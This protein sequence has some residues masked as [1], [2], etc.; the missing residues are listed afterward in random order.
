MPC[1]PW[2]V[3]RRAPLPVGFPRQEYW[4]GLPFP[5]P[6]DLPDPGLEPGSAELAGGFFSSEPLGSQGSPSVSRSVGAD[7]LRPRGLQPTR[8]LCPWDS[9]GKRA[10]IPEWVVVQSLSCVRLSAT[11]W[12]AP[13]L[14]SLSFTLSQSLL[15][16]TSLEL[17]MP[18]DHL[19]LC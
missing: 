4:S 18:S 12:T 1:S 6:G 10:R 16:L 5:S 11:P 9:P 3:A 7:S 19:I 15:G 14:T 2:T 8:L 13:H 17:V